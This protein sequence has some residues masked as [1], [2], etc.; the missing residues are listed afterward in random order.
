MRQ[1]GYVT[2]LNRSHYVVMKQ[3][4]SLHAYKAAQ[5]L[6]ASAYGLTMLAPLSK[7]FAL[8]DQIRR[9][10]LSIPANIAEGY[11]LAT[12]MQ[13]VRCLRI[14]LGSA[15]E[16]RSHLDITRRLK[17]IPA[18]SIDDSIALTTRVIAMLVGLLR[19]LSRK[20]PNRFPLRVS[21]FTSDP[22]NR[23]TSS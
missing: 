6:A 23:A 7:H 21:R 8:C 3:L 20:L 10:S 5:D 13:F 4:E 19:A 14:S 12:T 17:L 11:A 1:K 16:L 15:A 2:R 9:S 22:K 18:A